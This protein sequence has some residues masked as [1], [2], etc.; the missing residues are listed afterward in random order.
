[1]ASEWGIPADELVRKTNRNKVKDDHQPL[2]DDSP[3]Y[4]DFNW[5]IN[6][7][8]KDTAGGM[9]GPM[10]SRM[11]TWPEEVTRMLYDDVPDWVAA[12]PKNPKAPTGCPP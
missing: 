7:Q 10:H 2:V 6:R 3:S 1:M 12:I 8:S 11:P 4:E 9:S 5:G